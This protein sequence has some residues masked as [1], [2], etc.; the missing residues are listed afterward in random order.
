MKSQ[1]VAAVSAAVAVLTL[2]PRAAT[3]GLLQEII[4]RGEPI[5]FRNVRNEPSGYDVDV[6]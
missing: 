6:A 5:A 4:D 1:R 3:A 2:L